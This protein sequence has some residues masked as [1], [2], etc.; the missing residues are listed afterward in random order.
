VGP[1]C[2]A[3]AP[4]ELSRVLSH[5]WEGEKPPNAGSLDSPEA[6]RDIIRVWGVLNAYRPPGQISWSRAL[7]RHGA[8]AA[9]LALAAVLGTPA[10]DV[11][12]R[13]SAG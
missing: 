7:V 9:H 8:D 2:T 11:V 13:E 10:E 6:Y 1:E 5:V 4:R 3:F 12:V